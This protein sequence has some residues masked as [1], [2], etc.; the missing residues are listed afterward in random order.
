MGK[1]TR[2]IHKV[3]TAWNYEKEEDYLFNQ[4]VDGWE[5]L[6]GGCFYSK[7]KRNNEKVFKYKVDFNPLGKDFN[8]KR[9]YVDI[10]EDQG[11]EYVNS[12]FNGWHYFKKEYNPQLPE[13]EYIVYTDRTSII[14]MRNRWVTI[15]RIIQLVM[16]LFSIYFLTITASGHNPG[17]LINALLYSLGSL[18]LLFGIRK[19]RLEEEEWSQARKAINILSLISSIAVIV[20]C[21][22]VNII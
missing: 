11:W 16:L 15:A 1:D 3:F 6:R 13:E 21:I 9:L 19:M 7:Y 18:I 12:T 2:I 10:F 20:G 8:K 22:F 4:S 17:M 5:L 14:E